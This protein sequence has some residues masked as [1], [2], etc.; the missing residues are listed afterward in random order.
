MARLLR[1]IGVDRQRISM[2]SPNVMSLTDVMSYGTHLVKEA[3]ALLHGAATG[4]NSWS[5]VRAAL[6]ASGANVFALDMLGSG[7][8]PPPPSAYG[9]GEEVTHLTGFLNRSRVDLFRL[10]T[11]SIRALFGLHLRRSLDAR[12]TRLTF[13]DAIIVGVLREAAEDA[14]HTELEDRHERF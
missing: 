1:L 6:T 3:I 10:V 2:G 11:H 13:I 8:S 14:A 4:S 9:I 5:Q 12:V 7:S